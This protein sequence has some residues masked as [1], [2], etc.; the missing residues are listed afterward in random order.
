MESTNTHRTEASVFFGNI[1]GR[2]D[3]PCLMFD[4]VKQPELEQ[5]DFLL[6]SQA[7]LKR[8][9]R[10]AQTCLLGLPTMPLRFDGDESGD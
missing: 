4:G 10:L 5:R 7:R 2:N 1:G 6:K 9:R 3:R 8:P